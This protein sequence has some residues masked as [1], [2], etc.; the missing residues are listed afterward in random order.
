MNRSNNILESLS[1]VHENLAQ[2]NSKEISLVYKLADLY[3]QIMDL[4]QE[5]KS[6]KLKNIEIDNAEK[7][8]SAGFSSCRAY[9][10]ELSGVE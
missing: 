9:A 2:E 8:G 3:K 10:H 7:V 5:A 1:T 4:A 6:K